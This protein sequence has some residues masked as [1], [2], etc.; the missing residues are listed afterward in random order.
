MKKELAGF[1]VAMCLAP[2][3][4]TQ[5][6]TPGGPGVTTTPNSSNSTQTTVNRPMYGESPRTFELSVPMLSTQVK[7]GETKTATISL[8]RGKDFDEDVTL[9]LGGI[10]EGVTIEPSTPK[11][12]RGDKDVKLNVTAAHDAAV[13]EFTLKVIGHPSQGADATSTMKLAVVKD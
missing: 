12:M 5:T 9:Q 7:Q 6:S 13:G 3:G 2:M 4:C 8:S 1:M 11:I 10:P